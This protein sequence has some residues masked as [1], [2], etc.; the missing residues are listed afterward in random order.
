MP[1]YRVIP[2]CRQYLRYIACSHRKMANGQAFKFLT[3]DEFV[4]LE[5]DAKAAYLL[6]AAE[7]LDRRQRV[8]RERVK[9]IVD[10]TYHARAGSPATRPN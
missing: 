6:S 2:K 5:P 8:F 4:R 7:E 1:Q 3:H 10:L 9:A